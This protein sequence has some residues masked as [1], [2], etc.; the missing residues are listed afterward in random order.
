MHVG[1]LNILILLQPIGT[2]LHRFFSL[3]KYFVFSVILEATLKKLFFVY[4]QFIK[5]VTVIILEIPVK[6]AVSG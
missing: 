5:P 1:D 6:Y 2:T 4:F 3:K